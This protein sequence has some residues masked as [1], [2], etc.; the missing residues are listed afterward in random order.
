MKINYCE[1]IY[2]RG[3][4]FLWIETLGSNFEAIELSFIIH[5]ENRY[6]IGTGTRGWDPPQEPQK[7]VPHENKAIISINMICQLCPIFLLR[8]IHVT[9]LS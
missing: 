2:F 7:L 8:C 4:Q 3:Y 5:T 1:W 9:M 6:F